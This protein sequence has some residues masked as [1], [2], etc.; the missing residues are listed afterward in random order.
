MLAYS[1]KLNFFI[2]Q[3]ASTII[4]E[5]N[6]ID[7]KTPLLE[8]VSLA[9]HTSLYFTSPPLQPRMCILKHVHVIHTHK[10]MKVICSFIIGLSCSILVTQIWFHM[11]LCSCLFMA[12]CS[13]TDIG[14]F[15]RNIM[16]LLN[17]KVKSIYFLLCISNRGAATI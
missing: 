17:V 2:L 13:N 15:T 1:V 14:I 16:Y 9:M 12:C 3:S 4:R 11:W 10:C 8:G 6:T 7:Q 5:D